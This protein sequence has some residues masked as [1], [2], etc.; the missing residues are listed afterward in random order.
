MEKK[1]ENE[2]ETAIYRVMWGIL[3]VIVKT[4]SIPLSKPHSSP[5]YHPLHNPL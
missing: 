5:S 4:P 3:G 2:K 1:M